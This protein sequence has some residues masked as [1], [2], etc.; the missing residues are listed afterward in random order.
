MPERRLTRHDRSPCGTSGRVSRGCGTPAT[1]LLRSNMGAEDFKSRRRRRDAAPGGTGG[2]TRGKSTGTPGARPPAS[3]RCRRSA[4]RA[5]D[6][7]EAERPSRAR[8]ACHADA[9][10]GDDKDAAVAVLPGLDLDGARSPLR[11]G[12]LEGVSQDLDGDEGERNGGV[13]RD[14]HA[15]A[16][17][18]VR[19]SRM[20]APNPS[21]VSGTGLRDIR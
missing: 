14:A 21:A 11:E 9:V 2:A 13:E 17:K 6:E 15:T 12:V 8:L 3:R 18:T 19:M 16:S 1:A 4:G 5:Q 20:S 10:V 7:G